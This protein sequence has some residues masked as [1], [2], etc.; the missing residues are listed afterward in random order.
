MLKN[1]RSPDAICQL[2][3]EFDVEVLP[4]SP[5][6]GNLLYISKDYENHDLSS[7]QIVTLGVAPWRQGSIVGT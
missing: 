3:D 6:F 5:S 1:D 2:A 7:M 4:V